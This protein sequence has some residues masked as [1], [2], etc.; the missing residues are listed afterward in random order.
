MLPKG[1]PA[2]APFLHGDPAFGGDQLFEQL[3]HSCFK[4]GLDA[5]AF[6]TIQSS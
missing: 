2:F 1:K 3:F 5:F 6:E 4:D